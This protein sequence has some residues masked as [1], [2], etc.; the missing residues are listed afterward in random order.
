[1]KPSHSFSSPSLKEKFSNNIYAVSFD[2]NNPN[3]LVSGGW[4]EIIYFWDL[5]SKSS[6]NYLTG[7]L[8]SS[9]SIDYNH[10]KLVTG[11]W[12]GEIGIDLW[13][14]R[15]FKKLQELEWNSDGEESIVQVCKFSK[16]SGS[17]VIASGTFKSGIVLYEEG[18]GTWRKVE[19]LD[20]QDEGEYYSG[21]FLNEK[22]NEI[23][24]GN[25]K[26]EILVLSLPV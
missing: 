8:V 17:K 12:K 25:N 16:G 5:R 23:A 11:T 19:T 14:L 20:L 9:E 21:D 1:M 3:L 6:T 2:H 26:G 22:D 13:D 10:E 15:R 18:G 7:P 24:F 4:D